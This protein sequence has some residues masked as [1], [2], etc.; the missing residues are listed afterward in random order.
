MALDYNLIGKRLKNARNMNKLT[1]EQLAEKLNVSIAFISRIEAGNIEIS[2]KRLS[3]L[4]EVLGVS[5][6]TILNGSA[7][8]SSNYLNDEFFDLLKNCP[9]DKLRLIYKV[10]KVI[11]EN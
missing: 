9:A 10:A 4:C 2:L 3:Q 7:T 8:T 11:L 5:E 6:G 1:L